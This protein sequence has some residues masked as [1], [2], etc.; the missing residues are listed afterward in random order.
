MGLFAKR[1][2][3]GTDNDGRVYFRGNVE[4]A[5]GEYIWFVL[6]L[7]ASAASISKQ[8]GNFYI[9]DLEKMLNT[10]DDEEY[11]N[12]NL[13]IA[14]VHKEYSLYG[15]NLSRV[16]LVTK[17]EFEEMLVMSQYYFY[18]FYR[19]IRESAVGKAILDVMKEMIPHF[20]ISSVGR[21][22]KDF[23]KEYMRINKILADKYYTNVSWMFVSSNGKL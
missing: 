5:N 19:E 21:N 10:S 18:R 23:L 4:A 7:L 9:D 2:V 14:D 17:V 15:K 22:K 3:L 8:I 20:K 16:D 1:M 12:G 11:W 6:S 13:A